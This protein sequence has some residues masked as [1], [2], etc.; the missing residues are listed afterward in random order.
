M[1]ITK[2]YWKKKTKIKNETLLF[3]TKEIWKIVKDIVLFFG[4][5]T[6]SNINF[7]TGKSSKVNYIKRVH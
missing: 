6:I 7:P 4:N 5:L 2:T 3:A 1:L